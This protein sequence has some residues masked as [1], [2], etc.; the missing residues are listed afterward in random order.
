MVKPLSFAVPVFS[1]PLL[2]KSPIRLAWDLSWERD[3]DLEDQHCS[4]DAVAGLLG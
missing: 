2:H 1:F 4:R 3:D